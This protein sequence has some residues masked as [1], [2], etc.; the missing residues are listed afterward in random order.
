MPLDKPIEDGQL[1]E[2]DI[3]KILNTADDDKD[4][5][6]N[7]DDKE[8]EPLK[9]EGKDDDKKDD[10]SDDD[11]DTDDKKDDDEVED[12]DEEEDKVDDEELQLLTPYRKQEILKAFP[13][14]DKK[15]PFIFHAYY[16]YQQYTDVF[17]TIEDAKE[18]VDKAKTLDKFASEIMSGK[19]ENVIREV[20]GNDKAYRRMID[21]YIPALARVNQNA[22][23]HVVSGIYKNAIAS[24]LNFAKENDNEDL[25][26][27]AG[28]LHQFLFTT[29]KFTPHQRLSKD[30]EVEETDQ[31]SEER[32]QFQKERFEQVQNDMIER[33]D[34]QIQATISANIDPK[35]QMQGFVKRHAAKEAFDLLERNLLADKAFKSTM[36]RLWR[37]AVEDNYSAA[38]RGRIRKAFLSRATALLPGVLKSVRNEALKGGSGKKSSDKDRRGHLPVNRTPSSGN[39][40]GGN[41]DK[42]GGIPKG[43]SIDAFIMSD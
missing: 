32:R 5:D 11:D 10:D 35:G 17:P 7:D 33:M 15:F 30:S 24:M 12:D 36:E 2:G 1:G 3:L 42:K 25:A 18:A 34:N 6:K 38:S 22:A 13:G 40:S 16:G 31:I 29:N 43:M 39:N 20:S 28:V 27:A 9:L 26:K 4:D 37:A 8:D 23:T 21:D 41:K 19:I 14:L